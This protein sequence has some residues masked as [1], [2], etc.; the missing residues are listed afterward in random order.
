LQNFLED[1]QQERMIASL[2]D[3]ALAQVARAKFYVGAGGV[4]FSL[5]YIIFA[6]I[7]LRDPWRLLHHSPFRLILSSSLTVAAE[8]LAAVAIALATTSLVGFQLY[9]ATQTKRAKLVLMSSVSLAVIVF[10][11]WVTSTISLA[12][13]NPVQITGVPFLRIFWRPIVPGLFV[14]GVIWTI[15]GLKNMRRELSQLR[16][17]KY[18]LKQA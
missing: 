10:G 12:M 14:L 7:Q 18:S 9:E 2:E 6:I 15:D 11:F 8:I 4:L 3:E 16:S 5:M 13:L 17:V 1:E